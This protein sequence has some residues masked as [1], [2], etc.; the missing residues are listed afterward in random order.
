MDNTEDKTE[1]NTKSD[2]KN[3]ICTVCM[4]IKRIDQFYLKSNGHYK[5]PCKSCH[6]EKCRE[7]YRKKRKTRLEYQKK[8]YEDH[9][10]QRQAYGREYYEKNKEEIGAMSR[11]NRI[12]HRDE[13][14]ANR[15]RHRVYLEKIM[16]GDKDA[17]Y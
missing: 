15:E 17:V 6:K 4:V 7:N 8:Y 3:K 14:R 2:I 13:W 11:A 12:K 9:K 16:N 10:E 1:V 5:G